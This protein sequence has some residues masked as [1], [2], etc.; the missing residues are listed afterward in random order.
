M[1][2]LVSEH[3]RHV[4]EDVQSVVTVSLVVTVLLAASFLP[5]VSKL[6]TRSLVPLHS[7]P[8]TSLTRFHLIEWFDATI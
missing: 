4:T 5:N 6:F 7:E 8:M 3:Q 1:S 2:E